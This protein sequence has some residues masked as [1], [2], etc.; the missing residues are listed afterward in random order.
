[1]GRGKALTTIT[2]GVAA[3]EILAASAS[4][5]T[6]RQLFYSLVSVGRLA[7][8][9]AAYN[10]LKR[11]LKDLRE[12]GTIPWDWLVDHTRAVFAPR[13]WDGIEGLL[14]DS[15]RLYRRDLMR[16]QPVAIQL[17]A[18]SDSIGSVIAPVADRYTIPTFI[19]RGY[20]ARG[21]LW[22]AARDAVAAVQAGKEVHVLH[23]GD[24]DP[25]GLDIFRDVEDTLRRY[26]LA[27]DWQVPVVEVPHILDDGMCPKFATPWLHISRLALTADQVATYDLP[28][29]PP[30]ATDVR[31][32]SFT[33][34]GAV[35]VEALPVAVLLSIVEEAIE[36]L[37]DQHALHVA[38]AAEAS[39]RDIATRI[40]ATPVEALVAAGDGRDAH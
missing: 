36:D 32:R 38:A 18:E 14:A 34:V 22:N 26:A 20:G 19:G 11:I 24:H 4:A 15:A 17:W 30:K 33:G 13:T 16:A 8:T 39:E 40:A 12:D 29:R 25:S 28:A 9:E 10:K 2:I 31:T 35:E 37:I 5:M 21:Y 23:V 3:A 6:L 1:M 27:V 7:K